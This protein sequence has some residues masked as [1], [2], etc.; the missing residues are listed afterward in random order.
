MYAIATDAVIKE[1]V[2]FSTNNVD[3]EQIQYWRKHPNLH[4][5][6]ENL[7]YKKG[8]TAESF[9]CVGVVLTETDLDRLE[10]DIVNRNLPHTS[11]FFFGES[12]DESIKEDLEFIKAAK[13]SISDGLTVY[14]TS[15]W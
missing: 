2:D 15:W 9:N 8:G 10:D 5:W 13:R 14:Y 7:Y 11:G 6:M 4:G 3:G 1:E 12:D